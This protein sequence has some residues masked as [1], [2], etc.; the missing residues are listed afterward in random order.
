M[1][2]HERYSFVND[3]GQT[4]YGFKSTAEYSNFLADLAYLGV[5]SE[6]EL[7]VDMWVM[8]PDTRPNSSPA[9]LTDYFH[10]L[11]DSDDSPLDGAHVL[12]SY[13]EMLFDFY[14]ARSKD[15]SRAVDGDA[16]FAEL[17]R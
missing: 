1:K 13:V 8:P 3:G 10:E 6:W 12:G 9:I 11:W 4:Q 15:P 2:R 16:E 5:Y 17:I 14:D 7:T